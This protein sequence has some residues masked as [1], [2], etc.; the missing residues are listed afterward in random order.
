MSLDRGILIL[1]WFFEGHLD[2]NCIQGMV[3]NMM[4]DAS[5]D[6]KRFTNHSLHA[7]GTT[8]LFD[9]G[10]Q[11]A[12]IQKCSDHRSTKALRMYERVTPDQDL[13]VSRILHS[14]SKTLYEPTTHT[15]PPLEITT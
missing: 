8:L 4:Q 5:T 3:K 11:E 7:T 12:S 13:T 6:R 15:Q 2:Q 14:T 10:V 1:H 9:A